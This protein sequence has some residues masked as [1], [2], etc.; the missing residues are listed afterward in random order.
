LKRKQDDVIARKR[1][2]ECEAKQKDEEERNPQKVKSTKLA[3]EDR[4]SDTTSFH[5]HSLAL[6]PA[7]PPQLPSGFSVTRNR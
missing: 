7:L 4:D 5:P 6:L 1:E 2:E 3:G